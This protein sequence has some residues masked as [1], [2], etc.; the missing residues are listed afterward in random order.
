[1]KNIFIMS[2]GMAIVW[3][4]YPSYYRF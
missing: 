4:P 2:S 3:T 1:L